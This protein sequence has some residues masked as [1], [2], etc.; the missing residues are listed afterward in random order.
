MP[1]SPGSKLG[2]Y[3]LQRKVGA[4]GMAEV[5]EAFDEGLHRSVA[6]KVVR[7]E[8]GHSPEFQERFVREA[9]LA[10]GLEHPR[11]L[12]IYD[13]GWDGGAAFLVMPLLSGG[14]L[15]DRIVG[16]LG[17]RDLIDALGSIAS[18]LDFAHGRSVLHRD[19]KPSN[20][21]L[22]LSG[23][24][25]LADFGLAKSSQISSELTAT[26]MVIGTPNYMAPEQALGRPVDPRADQYSLGVVAFELLTGVTPFRGETPF[27]VLDKHVRVPPPPPS[28][29]NQAL[30]PAV[31]PVLARVLAKD[32]AE[33]Y[34]SCVAFVTELARALGAGVTDAF[35]I[36][37]GPPASGVA[38]RPG[39]VSTV[40]VVA[41]TA[42][43]PIPPPS[44]SGPAAGSGSRSG[45]RAAPAPT[46]TGAVVAAIVVVAVA[47]GAAIA[48]VVY[49][50][51]L[52]LGG[53][54]RGHEPVATP[55]VA[56]AT[57]AAGPLAVIPPPGP[58]AAAGASASPTPEAE[59]S[60]EVHEL[61]I[62][63]A[64][65]SQPQVRPT[66]RLAEPR[67]E[68]TPSVAAT[69]APLE[70]PRDGNGTAPAAVK[71][72]ERVV[73]R[74][75]AARGIERIVPL[76]P[77]QLVPVAV[78]MDPVTI[79]GVEVEDVPD[80]KALG[81]ADANDTSKVGLKFVYSNDSGDDEFKCHYVVAVLD[82]DG[83]VLGE[84]DRHASLN[85]DQSH[86]TN[87]L[88]VKIRTLDYPRARSLRVRLTITPD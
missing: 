12:P 71:P 52:L 47:V 81:K 50:K 88:S 84:N 53:G 32:P 4:G 31:D 36:V 22:D 75:E 21:L 67:T 34:E 64:V 61:A 66:P 13:F 11:I 76:R 69:P 86:D 74:A 6:V 77:G 17:A 27:G 79:E 42:T 29:V 78:R 2:R 43:R 80:A 54:A 24:F 57:P 49:L 70:R 51:P 73:T 82:A 5:W 41:T 19:V 59:P 48:G 30:P 14:S 87:K 38:S 65:P 35:T 60:V 8:V 85:K 7:E 10:A 40:P 55:Q 25:L 15:K 62:P 28:S 37:S 39:P 26:G 16:P 9:R 56:S 3:V 72:G 33:R 58:T 46:S 20:V 68:A 18:A 23:R 1:V 44:G 45:S 63:T 83:K